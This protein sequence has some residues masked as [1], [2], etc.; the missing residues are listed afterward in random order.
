MPNRTRVF[1]VVAAMV[2]AGA[3]STAIGLLV[4]GTTGAIEGFPDDMRALSRARAANPSDPRTVHDLA[5]FAS[6]PDEAK[7]VSVLNCHHGPLRPPKGE[8]EAAPPRR[9]WCLDADAELVEG[10]ISERRRRTRGGWV[11]LA[12]GATAAALAIALRARRQAA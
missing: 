11:L 8:G 12:V 7:R 6:L 4:T 5:R 2:A 1:A 10:V 3:A 9:A